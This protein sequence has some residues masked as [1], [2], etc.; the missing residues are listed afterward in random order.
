MR[1]LFHITGYKRPDQFAWL[2]RAVFNE[3][4]LFIIHVDQKAPGA[5]HAAFRS[6]TKD[7]PNTRFIPSVPIV[8]GGTGLIQAELATIRY[9][10]D[11]DAD[12][13]YLIN[14]SAQDYP[15]MPITELKAQLSQSWP[16]NFVECKPISDVHWRIRKRLWFRYVEYNYKRYFTPFP[17]IPDCH[18]KLKW[19][20]AWW[21][22]LTQDFC[23]WWS[24]D[25]LARRYGDG[26]RTA[27][28]PDEFLVQNVIKD[29]PFQDLVVP[30]C[31]HEIVWC[32]PGE[33][34]RASAHPNV[35]TM[36]DQQR[37][38]RSGAFF[39][40]KFDRNIDQNILESIARDVGLTTPTIA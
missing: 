38:T 35:L 10:L 22:I 7:H 17:R 12:W 14:L 31:K 36:H 21:H 32:N 1:L 15:L 25:P 5:V 27:G 37:L 33:P 9:A 28:M 29:S 20:G 16:H 40:R 2:Y 18:L 39:A 13:H 23:A 26:L 11:M 30:T 24:A 19:Y 8:W 34:L 6:I 4:D 3:E